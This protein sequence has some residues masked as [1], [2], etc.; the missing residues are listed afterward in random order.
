MREPWRGGDCG[1]T[2]E[3]PLGALGGG[4][5]RAQTAH[6][7]DGKIISHNGSSAAQIAIAWVRFADL[8]KLARLQRRGFTQHHGYGLLTLLT[9]KLA[10]TVRMLVAWAGDTPAGMIIADERGGQSPHGRILN[11][12]VDPAFRRQGIGREL[13]LAA[14]ALLPDRRFVLMVD[15]HNDPALA[16][17]TSLGY[18]NVGMQPDYYG[19]G[20]HGVMMEKR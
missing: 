3:Y 9:L 10:P 8:P 5:M 20:R 17:Y 12:C 15:E 4:A 18:Q 11:L 6:S 19:R 16:L 2:R 14:E 7:N 1:A 13:M